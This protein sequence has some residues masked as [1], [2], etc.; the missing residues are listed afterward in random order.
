LWAE[1]VNQKVGEE[2]EKELEKLAE[3]INACLGEREEIVA[4]KDAELG[5]ALV[6]YQNR[7]AGKIGAERAR[8]DMLLK[9]VPAV[10]TKLRAMP[11]AEPNAAGG[12]TA[13][14]GGEEAAER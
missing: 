7:L 10:A 5:D 11:A 2:E 6:E 4:E 12:E 14:S 3:K 13:S 8:I 9:A 1:G